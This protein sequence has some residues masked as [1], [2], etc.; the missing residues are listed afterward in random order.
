MDCCY[1]A[2]TEE[3]N[4]EVES[5]KCYKEASCDNCIYLCWIDDD[6]D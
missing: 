5:N 3:D 1:C 4:N 2:Y 6:F